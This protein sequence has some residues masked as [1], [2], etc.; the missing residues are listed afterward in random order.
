MI[1]DYCYH[2][3]H[4]YHYYHYRREDDVLDIYRLES[5]TAT[6]DDIK[7]NLK[8]QHDILTSVREQPWRMKRKL[9]TL[10]SVHPSA[11]C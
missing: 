3:H 7:D 9:R 2:D 6:K 5:M 4:S 11:W 10:R 8:I 1:Y